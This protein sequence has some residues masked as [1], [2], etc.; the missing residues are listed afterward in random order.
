M[1]NSRYEEINSFDVER[2]ISRTIADISENIQKNIEKIEQ[3]GE[4]PEYIKKLALDIEND[5]AELVYI[6][7][8]MVFGRDIMI[9]LETSS[10]YKRPRGD[11]KWK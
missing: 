1:L 3:V 4:D 6:S 10:V 7:S 9:Q 5:K 11:K 2:G 8:S